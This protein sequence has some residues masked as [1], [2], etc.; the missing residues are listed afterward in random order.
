VCGE[1]RHAWVHACTRAHAHARTRTCAKRMH[2]PTH[3]YTV[4][5]HPTPRLLWRTCLHALPPPRSAANL[6]VV[7]QVVVAQVPRGGLVPQGLPPAWGCLSRMLD[8][9]G[10]RLCLLF[11]RRPII[12]RHQLAVARQASIGGSRLPER[13]DEPLLN[14][15]QLNSSQTASVRRT[16]GHP[17]YFHTL[18]A[19][20]QVWT[21]RR[22]AS[23]PLHMRRKQQL[24]FH[25]TQPCVPLYS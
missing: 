17:P 25:S 14:L 6:Q 4:R 8:G 2:M 19:S 20:A 12:L 10:K 7:G 3:I 1:S 5:S 22:E 11:A 13:Q 23:R 21:T 15:T 9:S 16:K 18:L 24:S